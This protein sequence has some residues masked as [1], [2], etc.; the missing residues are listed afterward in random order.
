MMKII[1]IN[2]I[3]I[4]IVAKLSH[5]SLKLAICSCCLKVKEIRDVYTQ[6]RGDIVA[7]FAAIYHQAVSMA[8]KV[9]VEPVH[10]RCAG[11]QQHRSNVPSVT[12]EEH[13]RLNLA[14]PFLDFI[15]AE[16]DS[17]FSGIFSCY[18]V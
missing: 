7:V 11:R 13:Y 18:I 2:N 17:Q 1:I 10:P 6:Q 12:V 9:G 3:Y 4:V 8:D 5:C 15:A 14:I 16:L